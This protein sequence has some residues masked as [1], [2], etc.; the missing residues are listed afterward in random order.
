V[1]TYKLTLSQREVLEALIKLYEEKRRLIKSREIAELINKDEGT[2]RNIILSL[3]SLG[4]VESK[5]GPTGGYMPTLKAYEIIR[6]VSIQVPVRLR[7]E[8]KELNI[9]VTSIELLDMLNPEGCRAILKVQGRLRDELQVGDVVEIGPTKMA[10][11]KIE[12]VVTH[13]DY[14]TKQVGL[15]VLRLLSIPRIPVREIAH[16]GNLITIT[17]DATIIEAARKMVEHKVKGLPVIDGEEKLIGII[18]Q[19]DVARAIADGKVNAKVEEYMSRPPITVREDSDI[20]EAIDIMNSR[21]IGRVI[22][23]DSKGRMTG[24]VT[25]TD[26]LKFIA[27]LR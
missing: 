20:L 15:R 1:S 5:T 3:K 7:K 6:G 19:S 9:T 25:R 8:G 2:V 26:I 10:N 23:V 16:M 12:G 17:P 11:I 18:T 27:G 22:V 13:I 4:L 21:N 14:A 24:I